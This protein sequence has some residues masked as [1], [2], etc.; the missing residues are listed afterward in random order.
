MRGEKLVGSKFNLVDLA[1]SERQTKT[2]STG[3]RF[4]EATKINLSLTALGKVIMS[5]VQ[6][7][8]TFI[9]YRDSKLTRLLQDSLG[10]NAK[11]IM[12]ATISGNSSNI[13]ESISTLKYAS[14]AKYITNAP[15]INLD[16]KD[17]LL[18]EYEH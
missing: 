14:R 11:T 3:E 9:P 17:A 18:L 1:G 16:P 2:G 6:G 13:D 5:L 12:V 15:V 4:L 10:G 8:G 7:K